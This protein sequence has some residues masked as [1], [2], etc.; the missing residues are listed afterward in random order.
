[1][2]LID[3]FHTLMG[4][5]DFRL[6]TTFWLNRNLLH[7]NPDVYPRLNPNTTKGDG[8]ACPEVKVSDAVPAVIAPLKPKFYWMSVA[9]VSAKTA[10]LVK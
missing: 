6:E 1:M 9:S 5:N 7:M 8:I 10:I 4:F 3:L 2:L